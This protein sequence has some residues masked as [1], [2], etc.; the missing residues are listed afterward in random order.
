MFKT[1]K[2]I[3]KRFWKRKV[4]EEEDKRKKAKKDAVDDKEK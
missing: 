4:Q 2:H 1:W 3:E